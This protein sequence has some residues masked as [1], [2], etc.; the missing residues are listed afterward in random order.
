[1]ALLHDLSHAVHAE[2]NHTPCAVCRVLPQSAPAL[3]DTELAVRAVAVFE[4][5]RDI[6]AESV[7]FRSQ[8]FLA[9]A[10][11]RGPPALLII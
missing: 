9:S 11:P 4:G 7:P 10:V 1:M 6:Q 3:I 5:A 8:I 2:E